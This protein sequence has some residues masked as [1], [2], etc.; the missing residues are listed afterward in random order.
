MS[1]PTA[2]DLFCGAGGFSLGFKDAGF[3]ML[4]SVDLY[5]EAIEVYQ[6]N[7]PDA[8]A[9][10]A[11]LTEYPPDK[12]VSGLETKKDGIDVIIGGPP[13]QGFSVMGKQDPNDERSGLLLRFAYYIEEL[14]PEY[15]VMENVPGLLTEKSSSY[16]DSFIDR[17]ESAGY[18]I[19][20]PIKSVDASNYGV[21][22]KRERVIVIGHKLSNP[23]PEYP[24]PVQET[25]TVE[26]A[27]AG[28]PSDIEEVQLDN[29]VYRGELD[30]ESS[31]VEEINSMMGHN[32]SIDSLS[33]LNPV[34]HS[35]SVRDRFSEVEQGGKDP[36]SQFPRLDPAGTSPTLRAGSGS[37]RG[38]HTPARPIHPFENR[39]I[40]VREAARLQSFPDWYEFHDTKYHS[41]RQIGN[42]VPPLLARAIGESLM[43][44]L[45]RESDSE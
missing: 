8:N 45:L 28:I 39:C 33:G 36:V 4:V 41:L 35:E 27:F 22:Q 26:S 5:D 17:V 29:G 23:A 21:P 11:D 31:Y 12:L 20:S 25:V 19:V 13:C 40:T 30:Y 37:D 15:F 16:L 9:V 7:L 43:Q 44:V 34:N 10:N 3:D 32:P 1:A 38:T 24:K 6:N 42:S 18:S 2:I 14:S